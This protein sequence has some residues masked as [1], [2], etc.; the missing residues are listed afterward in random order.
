MGLTKAEITK[1]N[2]IKKCIKKLPP[3]RREAAAK[4]ASKAEFMES[5]I[6]KLQEIIAEK[7]WKESYQ[8][9]ANQS[10][11]KRSVEGETYIALIKNFN[12]TIRLLYDMMPSDSDSQDELETWLQR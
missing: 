4:L 11:Y 1:F 3:E 7:G 10:G 12:S 5:E 2:N 9:G 8:N 6:N